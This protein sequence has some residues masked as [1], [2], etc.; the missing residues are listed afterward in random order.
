MALTL[1]TEPMPRASV[2]GIIL[3]GEEGG[4][5]REKQRTGPVSPR[6]RRLGVACH[7]DTPTCTDRSGRRTPAFSVPPFP[8][9][10]P[11]CAFWMAALFFKKRMGDVERGGRCRRV[12][13]G[14]AGRARAPARVGHRG[15]D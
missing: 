10:L 14:A 7:R 5:W 4:D 6:P 2:L 8:C 3:A 13:W 9:I 12:W 1:E 15:R 11:V